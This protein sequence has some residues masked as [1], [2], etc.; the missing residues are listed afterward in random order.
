MICCLTWFYVCFHP[1]FLSFTVFIRFCSRRSSYTVSFVLTFF[2]YLTL[3]SLSKVFFPL[4]CSLGLFG[5]LVDWALLQFCSR[6]L[7]CYWLFFCLRWCSTFVFSVNVFPFSVRVL[8]N[9]LDDVRHCHLG[10]LGL[11]ALFDYSPSSPCVI[12]KKQF[13]LCSV[14]EPSRACK[15]S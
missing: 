11:H 2:L 15:S 1:V 12:V 3:F 5:F 14:G 6:N 7:L 9:L 10:H 13:F 4:C 8:T